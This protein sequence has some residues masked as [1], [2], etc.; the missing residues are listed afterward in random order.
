MSTCPQ[1]EALPR[2]T[3][4]KLRKDILTYLRTRTEDPIQARKALSF[5]HSDLA[6][7]DSWPEDSQ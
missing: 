4:Q 2:V 6:I 7:S 1:E 3:I 5:A